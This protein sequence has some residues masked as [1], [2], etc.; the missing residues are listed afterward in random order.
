MEFLGAFLLAGGDEPIGS[1][2][3]F[4]AEGYDDLLQPITEARESLECGT[5][6]PGEFAQIGV[7][8]DWSGEAGGQLNGFRVRYVSNGA[9]RDSRGS[10]L[11]RGA[12]WS[13]QR[14]RYD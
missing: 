1:A 2:N 4:P 9:T 13:Q 7:G 6:P 3:G 5:G 14:V 10:P 11:S 8:A 12:V